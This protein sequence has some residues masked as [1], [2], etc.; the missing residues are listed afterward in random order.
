MTSLEIGQLATASGV[1]RRTIRYYVAIGLLPPGEGSGPRR[2]YSN[3]HINRLKLIR[4][5]K[6]QF[7]PLE[8]IKRRMADWSDEQIALMTSEP[9]P[10]EAAV[11]QGDEFPYAAQ[12][13]HDDAP[14]DCISKN[15]SFHSPPERSNPSTRWRRI[16]LLPDL[17]L[18]IR[19]NPSSEA[20]L[21]LS[22]LEEVTGTSLH[23]GYR[24][25]EANRR[26]DDE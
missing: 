13:C 14:S 20:Q 19:D 17:E 3:A 16:S 2:Y 23:S 18:H 22:M 10:M 26:E 7:L 8:E 6:D 11:P 15:Y 9:L 1:T 5:F 4:Q 21:L 12:V 24:D 25:P